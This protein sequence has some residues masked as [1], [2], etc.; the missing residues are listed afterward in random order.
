MSSTTRVIH[1]TPDAVFNVLANGWSFSQWV[2]GASRV[3]DVTEGWPAEGTHI[4][5]SV[6]AWPV[7]IDDT[8]TV[9][10]SERPT[11]LELKVRAWPS[12]EGVVRI[13][14][15]EQGGDTRVTIE[16]EATKG[17]ALLIPKAVRDLL[18]DRRNVEALRRLATLVERAHADDA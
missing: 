2:V 15:E 18:L 13:R 3:R 12:G 9:R 8:T 16:E 10:R 14:C 7:L 1:G 11:L 4:H 17:P 5:H 6:G